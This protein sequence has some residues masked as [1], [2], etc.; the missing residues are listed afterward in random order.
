MIGTPLDKQL[1]NRCAEGVKDCALRIRMLQL[2]IH[3]MPSEHIAMAQYIFA[4]LAEV[5]SHAEVNLMTPENLATVFGPNLLRRRDSETRAP[6]KT[7]MDEYFL[8]ADVIAFMIE[9]HSELWQVGLERAH[10]H[11]GTLLDD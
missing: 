4:F 2:L 5:A 1:T 9:N 10:E 6:K 8:M 11:V 3:L 7:D